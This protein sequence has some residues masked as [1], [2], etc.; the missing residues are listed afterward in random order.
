MD[1]RRETEEEGEVHKMKEE[2]LEVQRCEV[3][4]RNR[5]CECV[6]KSK[7]ERANFYTMSIVPDNRQCKAA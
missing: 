7:S 2:R 4:D 3:H 1:G 6:R 5:K